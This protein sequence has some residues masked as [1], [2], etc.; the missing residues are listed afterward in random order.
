[1]SFS[2]PPVVKLAEQL[3][4]EIELAVRHFARYHKYTTGTDLRGH[5]KSVVALAH[6]AWRDRA[7]QGQWLEQLVWAVDELKLELQRRDRFVDA[8]HGT[9]PRHEGAQLCFDLGACAGACVLRRARL[10]KRLWLPSPKC[11]AAGRARIRGHQTGGP[12]RQ[13]R[14]IGDE[15][16]N[17]R[18]RTSSRLFEG[19]H[20]LN[21]ASTTAARGKPARRAARFGSASSTT[22][23]RRAAPDAVGLPGAGIGTARWSRCNAHHAHVRVT[24]SGTAKD[25]SSARMPPSS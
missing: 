16:S 19:A 2:L 15:G 24:R 20:C 10:G 18:Y 13:R 21:A 25:R 8:H 7:R 1:M 14:G 11:G 23:A 9:H 12:D 6:R 22:Y 5:A 3:R 4:R 17:A